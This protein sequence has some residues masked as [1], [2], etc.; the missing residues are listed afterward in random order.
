MSLTRGITDIN[1][2]YFRFFFIGALISIA[3]YV[4]ARYLFQ[5]E[6]AALYYVIYTFF[7]LAYFIVGFSS[8]NTFPFLDFKYEPLNQFFTTELINLVFI[9]YFFF[10]SAFLDARKRYPRLDVIIMTIVKI[11]LGIWILN[12]VLS[13][14]FPGNVIIAILN[15]VIFLLIIGPAILG[16]VAV[17]RNW[18]YLER[19]FTAGVVA[20]II[21]GLYQLF[22][23]LLGGYMGNSFHPFI[24]PDT[25]LIICVLTEQFTYAGALG[26]KAKIKND[27]AIALERNWVKELETNKKLQDQL[28]AS[29]LKYQEKLEKE[30]KERSDEIIRRNN[31][32]QQEKFQKG[33][34]EYKRAAFESELKALRTQI[35]P[36]F[37]FNCM[38]I[39]SS[40]I[41]R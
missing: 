10:A 6:K 38:N 24:S 41:Y 19:F 9:F 1:A 35:N 21:S 28:H 34:E 33:L 8:G 18:S 2:V 39:L 3:F 29:M 30:V 11:N 37:L 13:F 7:I 27:K 23:R 22:V 20:L 36:H 16:T 40:F 26:Y 12:A 14:V 4:L 25:M 32:L 15:E 5:R 17:I 31:E